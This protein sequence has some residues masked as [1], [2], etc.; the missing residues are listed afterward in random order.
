MPRN[1]FEITQTFRTSLK[2]F[3]IS[4]TFFSFASHMLRF[5]SFRLLSEFFIFTSVGINLRLAI[6]P[7]RIQPKTCPNISLSNFSVSL[8]LLLPLYCALQKSNSVRKLM[9]KI[10]CCSRIFKILFQFTT[11]VPA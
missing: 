7:V 4:F 1:F 10:L 3:P 2:T 11:P 8:C 9:A 6:P 5:I